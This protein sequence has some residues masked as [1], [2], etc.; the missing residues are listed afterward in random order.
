MSRS[1]IGLLQRSILTESIALRQTSISSGRKAGLAS[2]GKPAGWTHRAGRGCRQPKL[3]QPGPATRQLFSTL[4]CLVALAPPTPKLLRLDPPTWGAPAARVRERP[5]SL[6]QAALETR[7]E[8]ETLSL[9]QLGCALAP[10]THVDFTCQEAYNETERRL[11]PSHGTSPPSI[12]SSAFAFG[13]P[14]PH[15][16]AQLSTLTGRQP[17]VMSMSRLWRTCR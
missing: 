3:E 5:D 8:G 1:L 11:D 2:P 17:I 10:R 6:C 7:N 13:R 14:S 9:R 4:D 12:L 15:S 16:L